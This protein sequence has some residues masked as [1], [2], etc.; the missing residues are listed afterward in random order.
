M[1]KL[2]SNNSI[3]NQKCTFTVISTLIQALIADASSDFALKSL[4]NIKTNNLQLFNQTILVVMRQTQDET[5]KT[6]IKS[7]LQAVNG[8]QNEMVVE[9]GQQDYSLLSAIG[10]HKQTVMKNAL[11]ALSQPLTVKNLSL[12]EASLIEL[13]LAQIIQRCQHEESLMKSMLIALN[14]VYTHRSEKKQDAVIFQCLEEMLHRSCHKS[15]YSREVTDLTSLIC[16]TLEVSDAQSVQQAVIAL[17][18]KKVT[19][20]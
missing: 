9:D 20:K 6:N 15:I 5:Q 12:N 2:L 7:V 10:S 19:K 18:L 16:Q 8:N 17:S 3:M 4:Q 13:F 11:Q 1:A 14:T